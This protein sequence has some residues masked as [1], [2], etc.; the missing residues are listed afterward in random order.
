MN[1]DLDSL[2]RRW[3]ED[4]ARLY[5]VVMIRPDLYER[6]GLMVRALADELRAHTTVEALVAAYPHA[7]QTLNGLLVRTGM[8]TEDLDLGLVTG[9]AFGMRHREILGALERRRALVLVAEARDRG[10]SWVTLHET[11]RPDRTGF[12][13]LDM[14]L[15]SGHAL[16]LFI[17][18]DPTTGRPLHGLQQLRLDPGTGD[19]DRSSPIED[20]RSFEDAEAWEKEVSRLRT[21]LEGE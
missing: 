16:H 6:A 13:K 7:S 14:H 11:G 5:P 1:D 8:A 19:Y 12:R 4:E 10:D 21:Y 18:P 2:V 3:R 9:A 20:V 15:A 17:E